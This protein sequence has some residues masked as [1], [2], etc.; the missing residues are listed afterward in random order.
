MKTLP[1]ISFHGLTRRRTTILHCL[2]L[3]TG[4]PGTGK[5]KLCAELSLRLSMKWQDVSEIAK[6]NGFTE[7]HDDTLDC[8]ILDEDQ[9]SVFTTIFMQKQQIINNSSY[10]SYS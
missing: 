2:A 7:G 1:L 3:F 4:T 5:S 6:K 8:P 10:F 9:V